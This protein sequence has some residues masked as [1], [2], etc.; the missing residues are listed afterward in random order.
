M[1]TATALLSFLVIPV[2]N[3]VLGSS[4][5]IRRGAVHTQAVFLAQSQIEE[6]MTLPFDELAS[7]AEQ[8]VLG[9]PFRS[10][11]DVLPFEGRADVRR[12]D[13]NISWEDPASRHRRCVRLSCLRGRKGCR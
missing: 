7:S 13:V 12:L 10:R 3:L 11:V 8:N 2:I 6:L 5:K 9:R 4:S 1:L